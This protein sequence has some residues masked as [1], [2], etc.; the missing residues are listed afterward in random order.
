MGAFSTPHLETE[1]AEEN[2]APSTQRPY[3]AVSRWLGWLLFVGG[4]VGAGIGIAD[5]HVE[6]AVAGLILACTAG[7][8]LLKLRT[9]RTTAITG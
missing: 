5:L 4:L 3:A 1:A 6:I 7:L 9:D 2:S 8:T